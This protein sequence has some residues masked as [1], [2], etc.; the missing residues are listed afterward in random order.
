[1]ASQARIDSRNKTPEIPETPSR[2]L[3]LVR[4][5]STRSSKTLD[6]GLHI[7]TRRPFE[8]K[9]MHSRGLGR[10]RGALCRRWSA[11]RSPEYE[12]VLWC[13]S[14]LTNYIIPAVT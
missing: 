5:D 12:L 8:A 7:D 11:G 10:K 2:I 4:F 3:S 13:L 9:P 14:P 1:M 6:R